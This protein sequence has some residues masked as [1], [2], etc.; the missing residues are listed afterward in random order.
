MRKGGRSATFQCRDVEL[1]IEGC[2]RMTW[3]LVWDVLPDDWAKR[4]RLLWM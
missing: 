2:A 4:M 3:K 1:G